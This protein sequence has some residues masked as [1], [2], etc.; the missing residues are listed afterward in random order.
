MNEDHLDYDQDEIENK[1][2]KDGISLNEQYTIYTTEDI[3]M[4][5][6]TTWWYTN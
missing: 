5:N 2:K 1:K 4:L 3:Q 6:S